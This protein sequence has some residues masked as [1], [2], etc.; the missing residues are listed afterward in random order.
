MN[1]ETTICTVYEEQHTMR[2]LST[3]QTYER[4]KI[5]FFSSL[6]VWSILHDN[7]YALLSAMHDHIS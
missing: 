5:V 4:K 6:V 7:L 1:L 2:A 3:Q